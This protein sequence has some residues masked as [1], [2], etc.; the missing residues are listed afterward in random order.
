METRVRL[1]LINGFP[2]LFLSVHFVSFFFSCFLYSFVC[3]FWLPGNACSP[4]LPVCI[5]SLPPSL[6]CHPAPIPTYHPAMSSGRIHY[7]EMYEMLTLMSPPLGLGKRC[8]SKVAYKV[9]HLFLCSG[10]VTS[11]KWAPAVGRSDV[12]RKPGWGGRGGNQ[13]KKE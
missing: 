12:G 8:P 13:G 4:L 11:R 7:T 6:P 9:D 2:V 5:L 10:L 1:A 3:L